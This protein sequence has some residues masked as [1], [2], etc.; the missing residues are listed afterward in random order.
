MVLGVSSLADMAAFVPDDTWLL[1]A[2][3]ACASRATIA[4]LRATARRWDA[5]LDGCYV[6][7]LKRVRQTDRVRYIHHHSSSDDIRTPLVATWASLWGLSCDRVVAPTREHPCSLGA[8]WFVTSSQL[9]TL[10]VSTLGDG[11]MRSL[12]CHTLE[13]SDFDVDVS[14][15]R[16]A[17]NLLDVWDRQFADPR[18]RRVV[19][20]NFCSHRVWPSVERGAP[21]PV[22]LPGR[23]VTVQLVDRVCRDNSVFNWNALRWLERLAATASHVEFLV[24]TNLQHVYGVLGVVDDHPAAPWTHAT[25]RFGL[26]QSQQ[27]VPLNLTAAQGL[28]LMF[29]WLAPTLAAWLKPRP[30]VFLRFVS[31]DNRFHRE[32]GECA[33]LRVILHLRPHE[34]REPLLES[35]RFSVWVAHAGHRCGLGDLR[36]TGDPNLEQCQ[37]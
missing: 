30:G 20:S 17:D 32:N 24:D 27:D 13:F 10:R 9:E 31:K 3:F 7:S 12:A 14:R 4:S 25:L 34:S 33:H 6:G 35:Q 21:L 2:D 16:T 1:I 15:W 26:R 29:H 11:E 18:L 23:R 8:G 36:P 22:M 28:A 5:L 19:V 37:L